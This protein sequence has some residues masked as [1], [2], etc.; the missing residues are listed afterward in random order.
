KQ[1]ENRI[2][3]SQDKYVAEILRKFG[4]TYGKSAST[5]ID[6]EKPL[7]KDPNGEDADVHIYRYL[8]GKPH[9]GLWYPK[10]SPFN[11]VAYSDS[12]YAGANLDRKSTTGGCQFLGC[13]LISWQSKK[14]T[15]V[16]T[17]STE[18]EY[19][20][21]ASCCLI[22]ELSSHNTKYTSSAL[23]QKVFANM[24]RIGKGFSGVDTLLFDG[25]LVQ[26]QVQAVEDVA[27]DEDDD[28]E[29]KQRV[30][31][32]EKKRQFKSSGLK[33][34]RKVGTAQ[35]VESSATLLWMIKRMHPNR[36]GITEL[37]ADEDFTLV[38]AE[39]DMNTDDTDESEP[40]KVEEVTKVVTAAKLMT[41]VVTTAATT[42]I[43]AQVPKASAPRRRKDVVIQDP[44]KTATASVVVHTEVKSKNKGK[45]ILIKELK[46][47]KRQAQIEQD[48]AFAREL[49]AE[50][51]ANIN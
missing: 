3:I 44:K 47:L 13:R 1:K 25:M 33:R 20:A 4:L 7:L 30:R 51:N 19:V 29:L 9:L 17:S 41:E 24:R 50:L 5:P 32:L 27:E 45:G 21:A 35:R 38:D 31:R 6:T 49:E 26:Q 2:F 43:V 16:A 48:E 37:D 28:N 14:H 36:G 42:I 22:D 46:P 15:A 11:L 23:T 8:K 18:A 12:D 40:A 34:L 10:D 39:E